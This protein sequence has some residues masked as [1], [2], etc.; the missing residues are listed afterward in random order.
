MKTLVRALVLTLL[1]VGVFAGVSTAVSTQSKAL[2][3][4]TGFPRPPM[5][6]P[7]GTQ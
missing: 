3:A 7:G 4:K 2:R 5:P 1:S 6:M